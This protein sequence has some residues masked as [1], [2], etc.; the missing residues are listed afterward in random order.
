M[1]IKVFS[2]S[3][4]TVKGHGVHSVFED[5]CLALRMF[6]DAKITNKARGRADVVHLHTVGPLSMLLMKIAAPRSVVTAHIASDSLVGSLVGGRR[7]SGQVK[8]YLTWFYNRADIVIALSDYQRK[9][10]RTMGV[11]SKTVVVP[12]AAPGVSASSP[13]K[14]AVRKRLGL[15]ADQQVVLSVGQIQ[16]RK[17]LDD[18]YECAARM[19]EVTFIWVGGFPFSLITAKYAKMLRMM[20]RRPENVLHTGQLKRA[21]VQAY[22]IAADVYFHPSHH[23]LGPVAVLEAAAHGLPLL[24]RDLECYRDALRGSYCAGTSTS[25]SSVLSA[26]L[27][28]S[29]LYEGL[30]EGAK[31]LARR[32]SSQQVAT[33]L[34]STYQSLYSESSV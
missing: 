6:T 7:F 18:F 33:D 10:L 4:Y 1:H 30:S 13:T 22:Y 20:K 3:V 5:N 14:Q 31:R 15:E 19:P 32:L 16:P 17:G 2:E 9:H 23:E 11:T 26:V 21:Q 27:S 24:L 28:D 12:N 34:Y 29:G 8:R 25:F